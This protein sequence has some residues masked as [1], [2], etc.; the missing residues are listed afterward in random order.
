LRILFIDDDGLTVRKPTPA[1]RHALGMDPD[2]DVT[3]VTTSKQAL[4]ILRDDKDWDEVWFDHDLALLPDGT[5]DTAYS[6]VLALAELVAW[7]ALDPQQFPTC[8]IH[9]Q[10]SVGRENLN[11]VLQ[12][13]NFNVRHVYW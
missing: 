5:E 9:T 13:W 8:V 12:R 1:F 3:V 2:A 4:D 10:N 11:F 7:D 6:V